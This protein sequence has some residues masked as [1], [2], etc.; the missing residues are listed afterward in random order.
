MEISLSSDLWEVCLY[1][2]SVWIIGMH[3]HLMSLSFL[4]T[5]C[6]KCAPLFYD[7]CPSWVGRVREE[8]SEAKENECKEVR[9]EERDKEQVCPLLAPFL[10]VTF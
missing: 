9:Q 10:S 4:V 1:L 7:L 5:H 2:L 8:T 3:H 6:G